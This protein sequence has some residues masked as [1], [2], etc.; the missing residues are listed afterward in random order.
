MAQG[1]VVKFQ[2][3]KQDQDGIEEGLIEDLKALRAEMSV[4]EVRAWT[5]TLLV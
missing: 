2:E 4:G 5:W 3:P 1:S